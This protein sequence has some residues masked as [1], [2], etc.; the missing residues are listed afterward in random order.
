[1][2]RGCFG[3]LNK[4]GPPGVREVL[5][6]ERALLRVSTFNCGIKLCKTAYKSH[7]LQDTW[8]SG[9]KINNAS[10]PVPHFFFLR[11][12]AQKRVL[13]WTHTNGHLG[14]CIVVKECNNLNS[15]KCDL[16]IF[17][18]GSS[19]AS[20]SNFTAQFRFLCLKCQGGFL[21]KIK[22]IQFNHKAS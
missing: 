5:N 20:W 15:A 7:H 4:R 17:R 22:L 13:T 19:G 3:K 12:L 10:P 16:S 2:I 14:V 21:N 8:I 6:P 9:D 11:T 1:M 18:H